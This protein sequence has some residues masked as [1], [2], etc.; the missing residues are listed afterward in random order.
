MIKCYC[1]SAVSVNELRTNI[2]NGSF[3][4][5]VYFNLYGVD[6]TKMIQRHFNFT[7]DRSEL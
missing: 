1:K 6:Q 5:W 3:F 7:K 2:N 4:I